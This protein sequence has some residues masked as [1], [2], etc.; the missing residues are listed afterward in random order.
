MVNPKSEP[1]IDA[2]NPAHNILA[3]MDH[4]KENDDGNHLYRGQTQF[5][6]MPMIPSGYRGILQDRP[7]ISVKKNEPKNS[8]RN[9]G[10]KFIGNF[11]W[12]L[13]DYHYNIFKNAS[14]NKTLRLK[15]SNQ[16]LSKEKR[17]AETYIKTHTKEDGS[18]IFFTH[19]INTKLQEEITDP[20]N[21]IFFNELFKEKGPREAVSSIFNK[22]FPK[23]D[24]KN[25]DLQKYVDN[26]YR[27]I[28]CNQIIIN[29]M[30]YL[31]GSLISQHYG[32]YSGLMDATTSIK[33]AAFF[34]THSPPNYDFTSCSLPN[35]FGVI[36]KIPNLSP[37]IGIEDIHK[38]NY[39]N[40]PGTLITH[41]ILKLLE[42]D[43]SYEDSFKSF[44]I[45]F[46][47]RT[48]PD[49]ERRYD[50]L[51]FPKGT[52][53]LSRIGRQKAAVIIPDEI[54][55]YVRTPFLLDSPFGTPALSPYSRKLAQQ[56]IEDINYREGVKCYFFNHSENNPCPK[57][58]PSY[59]WPHENDFF[60]H[61]IAYLF[62]S[63]FQYYLS[64]S[65]FLP[66]RMDLI[67]SGYGELNY[68]NILNSAKTCVEK[69]ESTIQRQSIEEILKYKEEKCMYYLYKAATLCHRGYVTSDIK[70]LE[71]GLK[72]CKMT[73]KIDPKS[74]PLLI[75][76][77][78]FHDALGKRAYAKALFNT[79][80]RII[81]EKL[82]AE[83]KG[84]RSSSQIF[85]SIYTTVFTRRGNA[86]FAVQFY[87]LYQ[88]T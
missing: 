83:S 30:G 62:L 54:Q 7:V 59:L 75:L 69:E 63:K 32:F 28:F 44:R 39:Y 6:Q 70:S 34:A 60:L 29:T 2:K 66:I 79:G 74:I 88:G 31:I 48:R 82:S 37:N 56:S 26:Y 61:V 38:I 5:Y 22:K 4:L 16:G 1:F 14:L 85:Q 47:N 86:D 12:D 46:E 17:N 49:G 81:E 10:R 65:I 64:P 41:D 73:R 21:S 80:K 11:I 67:D 51:K 25:Q 76:E 45:C 42:D 20:K 68:K 24:I 15:N 3:L 13:E 72:F 50:L 57:L 43:I 84:N 9:I 19:P 36:Y 40:A 23:L 77:I 53:S 52:I 78:I 87:E 33:I 35:K 18:L 71:S 58:T 8:L 55:K 27:N